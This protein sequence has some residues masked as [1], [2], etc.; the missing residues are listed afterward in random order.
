MLQGSY[1]TSPNEEYY[2]SISKGQL[3]VHNEKMND[4]LDFKSS[5]EPVKEPNGIKLVL[6]KEEGELILTDNDKYRIPITK[7]K[8]GK[9]GYLALKNN[10][11]LCLCSS[12][13][14]KIW[15]SHDK[16]K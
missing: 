13:H 4:V 16:E 8:A 7:K 15:D 12:H 5:N 2:A 6:T 3:E 14:E 9:G 1:L 11:S 10:G